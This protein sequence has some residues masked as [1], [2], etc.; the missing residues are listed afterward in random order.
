ML[1][2]SD[3]HHSHLLTGKSNSNRWLDEGFLREQ[4]KDENKSLHLSTPPQTPSQLV[5]L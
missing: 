1:G 5:L 4:L 2:P 3:T